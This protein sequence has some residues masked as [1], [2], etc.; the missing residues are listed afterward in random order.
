[1]VVAHNTLGEH[2]L[3]CCKDNPVL[4]LHDV[5]LPETGSI[6]I[7]RFLSYFLKIS[8]HTST[9]VEQSKRKLL[10]NEQMYRTPRKL[11]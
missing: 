1:M 4:C 5:R 10:R 9:K 6:H 2:C 11:V 8:Q 7:K 3:V